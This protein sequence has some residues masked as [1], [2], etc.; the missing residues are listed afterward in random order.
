MQRTL[1]LPIHVNCLF[2]IYEINEIARETQCF[3]L[4]CHSTKCRLDFTNIIIEKDL[5]RLEPATIGSQA[6]LAH[7]STKTSLSNIVIVLNIITLFIV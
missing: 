7:P 1:S 5:L 3:T 4:P 2:L 6:M